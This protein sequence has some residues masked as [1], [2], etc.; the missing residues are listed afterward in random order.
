M[1]YTFFT[2]LQAGWL[3]AWIPSFGIVLVQFVHMGIFREGGKRA[4]D[5]SWYTTKDKIYASLSTLFQL[6]LLILSIF[7]PLK[8]GTWWFG[9]GSVIYTLSLLAL[10]AAFHSYAS[11]PKGKTINVGIYR[12]SRN[13]MYFFFT[14]GM[15]GVGIASASLWM[16]ILIIP[17]AYAI[18]GV[19]LGE[20]RYCERTYGIEYR[21]Y[22]E[23]TPRYF[24]CRRKRRSIVTLRQRDA[25]AK[26][27]KRYDAILTGRTWWSRLYMNCI[28]RTD[29]AKIAKEVLAM[30]PDDLNGKVLDV[31]VGTAV[32]T[33]EKYCGMPHAEITGLDYSERMLEI[34]RKRIE[35]SGTENVRLV[36]G[37][38]G[39]LPFGD[40]YFDYVLSMSGFQAFPDKE[41]ALAETF[42]VLKPGGVF[43]GCFYVKGEGTLA[44]W[45]VKV[46]LNR[47]GFFIPPHFTRTDAQMRLRTLYG[48]NVHMT[49][50]HSMLLFKC[51][52]PTPHN[53]LK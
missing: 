40:D 44:D 53:P 24:G 11:V 39:H 19:I 38:V 43:L 27:I 46:V 42:R 22:K 30:L 34:T 29:D 13:P 31:P 35:E 3:N 50:H 20:E 25:Y 37:D 6:A 14:T 45:V 2:A 18:H 1:E 41:R 16:M 17:F 5:T 52:K 48:D 23:M 8:S 32:F 26:V 51:I 7:T 10:I 4:T 12:L 33:H 49:L 21:R 47:K 15:I 36:R 28:W 9:M